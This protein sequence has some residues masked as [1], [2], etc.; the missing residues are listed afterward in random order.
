MPI[1]AYPQEYSVSMKE[2]IVAKI[3]GNLL[4]LAQW[5]A[6]YI[7]IKNVEAEKYFCD[8]RYHVSIYY[9][10]QKDFQLVQNR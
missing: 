5:R 3:S 2:I 6:K 4:I 7:N 9:I 10:Y 1:T 8:P